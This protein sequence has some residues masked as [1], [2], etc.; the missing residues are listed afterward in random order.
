M[1]TINIVTK[2][3]LFLTISTRLFPDESKNTN[4][5]AKK[6][7]VVIG[8]N[9][10]LSHTK[11]FGNDTRPAFT[12]TNVTLQPSIDYY[13]IDSYYAGIGLGVSYADTDLGQRS[14]AVFLAPIVNLGYTHPI[15]NNVFFN[16]E[17]SVGNSY[18]ALISY[19][20]P[21]LVDRARLT[22]SPG[23]KWTLGNA[24]LSVGLPTTYTT[25][26]NEYVSTG[27]ATSFSFYF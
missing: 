24:L 4:L 27:M 6:G 26:L 10:A 8:G 20:E 11:F 3:I 1:R 22:I 5:F 18:Y 2:T 14:Y 19:G 15:S 21:G 13:A 9:A 7:I 16:L 25:G 17:F 12:R 23:I